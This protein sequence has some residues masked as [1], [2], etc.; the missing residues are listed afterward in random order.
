MDIFEKEGIEPPKDIFQAEGIKPPSIGEQNNIALAPREANDDQR[1]ELDDHSNKY[2]L[3]AKSVFSEQEI[4]GIKKKGAIGF[5]EAQDFVDAQDILPSG[6]LY[7]AADTVRILNAMKKKQGGEETSVGEDELMRNYI[8][9]NVEM[10]LRGMSVGGGISYYGAHL[11]AFMVEFAATGGI[12]KAAQVGAQKAV[13]KVLEKGVINAGPSF[14]QRAAGGAAN[15]TARS[16]AMPTLYTAGY[17]ERRLNDYMAITDKGDILLKESKETPA[18][19]A[20]KA[21]GYTGAEIASEM[22]GAAIGKYLVDP[23]KGLIKTPLI[24]GVN[25][26]PIKLRENLYEA[27]KLIKPN[28]TVSKA[29][30]SMGWHGMLQELGEERVADILKASLDM[31]ADK[32]YT[33]DDFLTAITPDKDQLLVEAGIISIAGGVHTAADAAFN[34]LKSKGTEPSE[35]RETVANMSAQERETFVSQ[36]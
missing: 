17:A 29:F 7:Q 33:F 18:M 27:Y 20:L 26:L 4:D 3:L 1:K 9:K 5:I 19:S 2:E 28:A 12:G 13:G 15:I 34:I 21:F 14:F 22:S 36:K 23:V 32:E 10:N 11:P 8:K 31:A 35:A 16:A 24:Q 25:K 30:S 6:G